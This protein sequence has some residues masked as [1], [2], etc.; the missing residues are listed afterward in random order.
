VSLSTRAFDAMP[1]ALRYRV[2]AAQYRVSEGELRRLAD[3]V[4]RDAAALDIG[5]WW[6]PWT[7]WLSRS[8]ASVHTFEPV[9]YIAEFLR[10]VSKPNVTVH[11][12]ALGDRAD[13]ATL[14][15]PSGG[16]G[17]E[18]RSTLHDAPFAN[19]KDITVAVM[20]LDEVQLPER[21]GFMKID[22]EGHEMQVLKGAVATI[23]KY[24]PNL[25]VEV[26]SHND[27]QTRVED[28][29]GFLRELGYEASFLRKGHWLPMSEF[30]LERD[31]RA[32]ADTVRR[33]GLI[34]NT[35]FT[36]G[37]VNNFLFR[38]AH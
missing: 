27:R 32:L 31:Q 16:S 37:Y 33:R 4:P 24:K 17:S 19:A 25:L 9:P 1:P 14:H 12:L 26:E 23:N 15:V 29:V 34:S 35:L 11:N 7:Y 20:P 18:G 21:I 13:S 36:R 6:G 5:A 3:F 30:D 10:S 2:I 22:V 38:Q 8:A 28:V